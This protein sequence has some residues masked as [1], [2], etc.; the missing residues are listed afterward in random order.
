MLFFVQKSVCVARIILW[1]LVEDVE[2]CSKRMRK[3]DPDASLIFNSNQ[4]ESLI[5]ELNQ[6]L[7]TALENLDAEKAENQIIYNS[8]SNLKSCTEMT[9][10]EVE[11]LP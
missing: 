7:Q 11:K 8:F 9:S 6:K 5:E 1:E 4:K 2:E 10:I 3:V